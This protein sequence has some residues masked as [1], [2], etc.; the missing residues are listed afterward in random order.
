MNYLSEEKIKEF[1]NKL[2]FHSAKLTNISDIELE[3]YY[4]IYTQAKKAGFSRYILDDLARAILA[5]KTNKNSNRDTM[6]TALEEEIN[7]LSALRI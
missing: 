2:I 3:Y 6:V 1:T 7:N 4:S 5:I